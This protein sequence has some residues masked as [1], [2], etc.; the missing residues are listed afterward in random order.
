M[1]ME[2]KIVFTNR[3][4]EAIDDIAQAI[5][6]PSVFILVDVNTESYVL[7]SLQAQSQVAASAQVI[8]TRSGD[9]NKNIDA[10]TNLWKN[11]SAN[12]ATRSSLLINLGGGMVTDLGGFAAATFMRGMHFINVPTTLLGA[13]DAS[14]GGK[15]AV[16]FAGF[17]NQ[18]GVFADADA[19]IISTGFFNTLPQQQLLSGYA[20]MLKHGLLESPEMLNK[21]LDYS[22]VYPVFDSSALL[23]LLEE[24]V[25]VKQRIV[26]QDKYDSGF[27]KALNLGH[28]V[29]HAIE[30]LAMKYQSPVPHGYA[31]AW[32]IVVSLILSHM[33]LGF[34]TELVHRFADYVHKNYG[35]YD[36]TCKEY[37]ELLAF[38]ARD[39]K[40][41]SQGSIAFTLLKDVGQPETGVI[42]PA[43]E[44]QSALD[45]Y[46]DLMHL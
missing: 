1:E 21:L 37:P 43:D 16:N 17:K 13:V 46:R 20:E 42:I 22:V 45:I 38:M 27:R 29:G 3:V 24:S 40:N 31:V 30:A 25:A 9:A 26:D 4:G 11:L 6:S 10:L 18:V 44:I 14:V 36:I 32:G 35:P 28:T 41:P 33:K 7:P 34:P 8:V 5:G 15:T 2:T 19:V 23:K 39:K 12:G